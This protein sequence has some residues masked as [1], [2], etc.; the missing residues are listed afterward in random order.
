MQVAAHQAV[1][2][3]G[4]PGVSIPQGKLGELPG[5]AWEKVSCCHRTPHPWEQPS[6]SHP[7]P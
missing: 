2:A 5:K 7:T 3:L 4:A 1:G 6:F